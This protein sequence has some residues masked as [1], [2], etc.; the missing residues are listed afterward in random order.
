MIMDVLISEVY[1]GC[2]SKFEE[3]IR[4]ISDAVIRQVFAA[5]LLKAQDEFTKLK[6]WAGNVGAARTGRDYQLSL[7]YR[8]REAS[9]FK[10]QVRLPCQL[11]TPSISPRSCASF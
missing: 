11:P 7:D 9:F 1:V 6:L 10:D 5:P 2:A 3:L 8:L 4:A